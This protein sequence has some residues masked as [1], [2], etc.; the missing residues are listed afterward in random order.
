MRSSE[1]AKTDQRKL[2]KE[3]F[4]VQNEGVA[5][6]R[7]KSSPFRCK[8][9]AGHPGCHFSW[10]CSSRTSGT[11]RWVE[12]GKRIGAAYPKPSVKGG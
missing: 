2:N 8:R 5:Q 10:L 7:S 11:M 4:L 12:K 6:C 3:D 9:I 1:G